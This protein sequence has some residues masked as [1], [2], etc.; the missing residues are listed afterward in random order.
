MVEDEIMRHFWSNSMVRNTIGWE[1]TSSTI[2][3][4]QICLER[5]GFMNE[6]KGMSMQDGF[7]PAGKQKPNIWELRSCCWYWQPC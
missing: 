4:T 5:F 1:N 6:I 7:D 2:F 3:F